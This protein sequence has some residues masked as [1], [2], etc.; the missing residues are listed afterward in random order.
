MRKHKGFKYFF[1]FIIITGVLAAVMMFSPL[2]LLSDISV[3]D[4]S[5]YTAEEI[6]QNSGLEIGENTLHYFGG[7][8]QELFGLRLGDIERRVENLPWVRT[9]EI[10]YH[11]PGTV[12]MTITER[13]AIAWVRHMGSYLL[14]DEE[15]YVMEVASSL[16][17]RYPEIRGVQLDKFA[18]GKKME[19]EK[20]EKIEWLIQLLQSLEQVDQGPYPSLGEVLDWVDFLQEKELYLSLDGRITAKVE[21]DDQLTYRLSYLKEL[22]YNYIRPGEK[23]MIDFFDEKYA[24]F[25]AE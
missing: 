21:L 17:D 6:I 2:L 20:P 13:N 11:F 3:N 18:L 15:G 5:H 9:A 25:I 23:G 12:Q 19:T 4:L 10:R 24:R 14:I 7:S 22:Y 8:F 16:D 1:V